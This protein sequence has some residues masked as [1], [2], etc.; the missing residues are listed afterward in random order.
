MEIYDLLE[1]LSVVNRDDG[2]KFTDTRRLDV[3]NELLSN[4]NYRKIEAQ[5]LFHLYSKRPLSSLNKS[6]VLVSSHVDCHNRITDCFSKVVDDETIFG[7][8]DNLITNASVICNMLSEELPENVL[9]AFTGDE[10]DES[11]GA[12]QVIEFLN[13]NNVAIKCVVVLDVTDM[14]WDDEADFT[15]ENNFWF[16]TV[17]KAVVELADRFCKTW[18]FVPSDLDTIPGY[19]SR[20]RIISEEAEPDESWEYDDCEQICFSL[21]LPTK[22][23]MHSNKGIYA[24]RSSLEK[25]ILFMNHLLRGLG[26]LEL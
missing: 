3:I 17:G 20:D 15:I 6:V 18:R 21:C 7:T 9:V 26:N 19:V 25:Y 8:Y 23:E 11:R 1:K 4:S 10:E 22:G 16:Y 13:S 14:A 2:E 24:R 12:N 5:G